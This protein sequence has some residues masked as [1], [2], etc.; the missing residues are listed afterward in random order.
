MSLGSSY[1][2]RYLNTTEKSRTEELSVNGLTVYVVEQND[3]SSITYLDDL[4]QYMMYF[5]TDFDS[6]VEIAKTIT[7]AEA[8]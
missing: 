1:G 6:V 2:F 3:F 5:E 4:T 8:Q 7:T